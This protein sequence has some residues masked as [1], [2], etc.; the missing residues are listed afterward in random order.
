MDGEAG[1]ALI[2]RTV[3]TI[4]G[5][6]DIGDTPNIT[7]AIRCMVNPEIRRE[8]TIPHIWA[9]R[10]PPAIVG[11]EVHPIGQAIQVSPLSTTAVRLL[12]EE[13]L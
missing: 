6:A 1:M 7:A 3:H 10:V 4:G 13:V 11:A 5:M 8:C 2:G 12:T 9:V